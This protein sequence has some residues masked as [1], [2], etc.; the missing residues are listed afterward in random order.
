[1]NKFLTNGVSQAYCWFQATF[2]NR[3]SL[4][5]VRAQGCSF[6]SHGTQTCKVGSF[7]L[8]DLDL[9]LCWNICKYYLRIF[10][11]PLRQ[12]LTLSGQVQAAVLQQ[13]A[14][15]RSLQVALSFLQVG[16]AACLHFCLGPSKS[17]LFA[18]ALLSS[19]WDKFQLL[20]SLWSDSGSTYSNE[21]SR[22]RRHYAGLG[23]TEV[24]CAF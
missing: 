13:Q 4:G 15:A 22:S 12:L 11:T 5:W 18:W 24:H 3:L 14:A 23:S 19:H 20:R 21:C 8:W 2:C 17:H 1:M 10:C 9:W 16:L 7:S 6:W